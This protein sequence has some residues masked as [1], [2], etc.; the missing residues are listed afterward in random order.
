VRWG[1]QRTIL[2]VAVCK[3]TAPYELFYNACMPEY[4][5]VKIKGGTY[6][7]TLV[8]YHRQPIFSSSS[9]CHHL[10]A[11]VKHVANYHPFELLAYCI[12]PDHIHVIMALP[13]HDFNYSTRISL[14][15]RRF[16]RQYINELDWQAPKRESYKKRQESGVWQ[17]RFWEHF[18][19]DEEDLHRHIDYVH[20]NPVKHGLVSQVSYWA[21]SSFFDYVRDGYYQMDWGQNED[22]DAGKFNFGE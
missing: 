1:F 13:E 17:R 2:I 22:V 12:L 5:R 8:T 14:I 6:F 21:H 4:R 20:Y 18:I 9:H 19:R 15:K 11:A 3:M 10:L 16:T 7:F